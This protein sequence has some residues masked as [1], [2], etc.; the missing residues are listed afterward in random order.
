VSLGTVFF[1]FLGMVTCMVMMVSFSNSF[2]GQLTPFLAFIVGGGVGLYVSLGYRN[3][4]PAIALASG[5][6][7]LAMFFAITSL[8]LGRFFSVFIVMALTYGFTT[9]AMVMPA[10]GEFNFAMGRSKSTADE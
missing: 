1:L 10:L 2:Q 6:L 5:V 3:P 4:S 9:T 7:P 8:L